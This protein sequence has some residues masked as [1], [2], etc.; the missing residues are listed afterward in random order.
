MPLAL[1]VPA[2]VPCA[3]L[4]ATLREAGGPLLVASALF[5]VY[6]GKGITDGHRSLAFSFAFRT[7][8]RTLTDAEVQPLIDAMVNAAKNKHQAQLR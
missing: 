3:D 7:D 2:D 4:L 5:D 6:Q 1:V 8:D